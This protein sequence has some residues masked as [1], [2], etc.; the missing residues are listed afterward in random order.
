MEAACLTIIL[1]LYLCIFLYTALLEIAFNVYWKVCL[2]YLLLLCRGCYMCE[3]GCLLG[4]CIVWSGGYRLTFRKTLLPPSSGW[5]GQNPG[6][7]D[8]SH[9][10]VCADVTRRGFPCQHREAGSFR[11]DVTTKLARNRDPFLNAK[12]RG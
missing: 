9:V 2:I 8:H 12:L 4:C 6:T 1:V 7:V 10:C 5:C 11:N 3:N